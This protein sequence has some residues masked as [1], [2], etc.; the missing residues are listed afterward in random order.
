MAQREKTVRDEGSPQ[1]FHRA[2][3][4][5]LTIFFRRMD[6]TQ[7]DPHAAVRVVG[8]PAST[9]RATCRGGL[10]CKPVFI[11]LASRE[12]RGRVQSPE[13]HIRKPPRSV[14]FIANPQLAL[15][16]LDHGLTRHQ[17]T[18]LKT[19]RVR[20]R[21]ARERKKT[22]KPLLPKEIKSI[23]ARIALEQSRRVQWNTA[24]ALRK[25]AQAMLAT[26]KDAALV[27]AH[28]DGLLADAVKTQAKQM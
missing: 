23:C 15:P 7:Q 16:P 24:A 1:A 14:R 9:Q 3:R 17:S 13:H 11:C 20:T 22:M 27:K 12:G 25:D 8:T 19:C 21:G 10:L 4:H 5:T 28:L 18:P 6:M 26:G 2:V